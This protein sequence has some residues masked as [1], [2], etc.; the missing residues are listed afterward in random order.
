MRPFERFPAL[1]FLWV[2][3]AMLISGIVCFWLAWYLTHPIRQLQIA[4]RQLAS[5]DL[6][7]RVAKSMG[8]RRD[9]ISDLGNDFDYMAERLQTLIHSQKQLLSDVSHELRS[10]LARLQVALGLT[11][12]KVDTNVQTELDRI[13]REATRL[14]DL[15][16]QVLTLSRLDTDNTYKKNDYV[17]LAQLLEAVVADANFEAKEK[18]R[19]I[20][21]KIQQTW[22]I[23]AN[24][25]L[26]HRA[27]EN[28]IR[29]AIHYTAKSTHVTINLQASPKHKST[30]QLAVC[31]Q[32]AGVPEDQLDS[33]FEPFV[34]ISNSRNRD[35]GGYGLGLAI[36]Q[37]AINLHN[38]EIIATNQPEGGLC[39]T[40]LLPNR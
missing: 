5:G 17:D 3:V 1:A 15:I 2:G 35:S 7:T 36:A 8:K 24:A 19:H 11:R 34:R 9:E 16:H 30:I 23:A 29:N 37:R 33:L 28:I 31:D 32:G 14:D 13:E 38:G 25:E 12:K 21:L 27:L 18:Q 26:L 22:T 6:N 20:M 4:S 39:I 40:V 10:P